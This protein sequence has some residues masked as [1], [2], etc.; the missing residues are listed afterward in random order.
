V[1]F[2]S[3]DNPKKETD[4]NETTLRRRTVVLAGLGAALGANALAQPAP[5]GKVIKLLVGFPPGQATDIVARLMA[6]RLRGVTGDNYVVENRPGQGGSLALGQLAKSPADGSTMML[7]HM[8]AIATNPHMYR[9]VPYDSLKDFETVGL[10][11]DLPFVLVCNSALP[12][13][14]VQELIVYAKANPETLTNASSGNGTV[15]HLA[16]EEFKRKAGIKVTHVAYK[17]SSPGLTDVMAGNVSMA[18]E[19]AAAVQPHVQ[20][21]KLRALAAGTST[22]LGGVL[23]VPTLAEQGFENFNAV[24]WLM[25][26]YPAGTPAATVRSTFTALNTAMHTPEVEQRLMAIGALP[27]YSKSPKEADTFLRS[28][29]KSWGEVVKRSGTVLD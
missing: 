15:S 14:N 24:T 21:G 9:S 19:T 17:G 4:M 7:A 23:A 27:R 8:S 20:S 22:R 29:F 5:A 1:Q 6:E 10:V 28:E 16:M 13:R 12:F 2:W 26:I 25:V 11:G 3:D 18:L